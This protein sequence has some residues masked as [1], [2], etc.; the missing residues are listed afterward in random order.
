MT[1]KQSGRRMFVA[2]VPPPEVLD[3]L[4]SFLDPR[5]GAADFRWTRIEQVHLTLAFLPAVPERVEEE[6]VAGLETAAGRR[7]PMEGVIAGGGAFPDPRRS[8][9]VYADL[10][11]DPGDRAELE[12]LAAGVRATA[13]R[14][15]VVVDG[16]RFRP[17][18]TLA[19]LRVPTGT[20]DWI[21]LLD[22]Y[23]GPPW[24]IDSLQLILS[25]LGVGP[26]GRPRYT[27]LADL[28]LG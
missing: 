9:V 27:T 20:S 6:L 5:R 3:H 10:A 2:L 23:R 13:N 21:K 22:G 14:A 4:E 12:R 17:H 25:E 8:R 16:Q 24:S 15:G 7:T 26:G 28:P 11:L 19:R 18:L 1:P